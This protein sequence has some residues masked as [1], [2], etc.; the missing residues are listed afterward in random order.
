MIGLL[1]SHV[2]SELLIYS[3]LGY[4][5]PSVVGTARH[6]FS[7]RWLSR[8]PFPALPV[9]ILLALLLRWSDEHYVYWKQ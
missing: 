1:D 6:N 2:S 8:I 5:P 7:L 9:C 3:R 4:E